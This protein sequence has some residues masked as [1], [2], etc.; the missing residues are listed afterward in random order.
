[1]G[2]RIEVPQARQAAAPFGSKLFPK[3]Y[4]KRLLRTDP[5]KALV[6]G[7]TRVVDARRRVFA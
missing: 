7:G 5:L 4:C 6:I 2:G 3:G 1:V